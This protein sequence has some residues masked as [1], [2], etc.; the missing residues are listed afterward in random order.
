[1][2][3]HKEQHLN[4]WDEYGDKYDRWL[5]DREPKQLVDTGFRYCSLSCSAISRAGMCSMPAA[6][7]AT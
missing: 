2:T 5:K 7:R 4:P 3:K 1:M 6:V